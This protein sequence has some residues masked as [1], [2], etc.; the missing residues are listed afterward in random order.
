MTRY[1]LD[2]TAYSY[3]QRGHAEVIERIDRAEWLGVPSIVLGELWMGFNLG[4]HLSKNQQL[5]EAFLQNPLVEEI[6]VQGAVPRLYGEIAA[7]LRRKGTPIPGNDIWIAA[8]A[9]ATG[10]VVLTFDEHF[11]SVSRIGH[12]LLTV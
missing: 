5:L 11:Q 3:F 7:E 9:A 2:T 1:C 12:V 4:R 8:C 10:S 6:R